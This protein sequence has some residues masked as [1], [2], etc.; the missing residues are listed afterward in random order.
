ML[1]DKSGRKDKEKTAAVQNL[2]EFCAAPSRQE[3]RLVTSAAKVGGNR[4]FASSRLWLNLGHVQATTG[5]FRLPG[6]DCFWFRSRDWNSV[7]TLGRSRFQ[8]EGS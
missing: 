6:R 3:I 8:T 2:S 7:S 4:F 1:R 5:L